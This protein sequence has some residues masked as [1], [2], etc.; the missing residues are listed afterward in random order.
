MTNKMKMF[1][2]LMAISLSFFGCNINSA[3]NSDTP[4]NIN[5]TVMTEAAPTQHETNL[6]ASGVLMEA[7]SLEDD[8]TGIKF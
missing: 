1:A 7:Y 6:V 2:I 5:N 3:N 4:G 8:G